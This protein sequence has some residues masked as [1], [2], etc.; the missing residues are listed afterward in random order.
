MPN[1]TALADRGNA[2]EVRVVGRYA[3]YDVIA[4]GGMATVHIGRLLGVAGFA[5]SVAVKRL[6]PHLASDPEFVAMFVDE[7]RLAARVRHP[8]VVQTLDVTAVDGELFLVMDYVHGEPLTQLLRLVRKAGEQMPLTICVHVMCGVLEGLHAAHEAKS[9]RG[10]PLGLV[11]RDVSPQNIIVGVDGIARVLDFGVAKAL[12]RIQSSDDGSLKGKIPYMSPE[13]IRG[14]RVDRTSDVYTSAVVLFEL[15]TGRR[16][17]TGVNEG[18]VLMKVLNGDVPPLA[19]TRQVPAALEA[20]IRRGLRQDPTERFATAHEMALALEKTVSLVTTRE[21]GEWVQRVAAKPLADRAALIEH[22]ERTSSLAGSY[23]APTLEEEL[24]SSRRPDFPARSSRSPLAITDVRPRSFY[25]APRSLWVVLGGS[26]IVGAVV[27]VV[28]L[29]PRGTESAT[30]APTATPAVAA[31]TVEPAPP[32]A[33]PEPAASGSAAPMAAPSATAAASASTT[34]PKQVVKSGKP[35]AAPA[36]PT[37]D[38]PDDFF[39]RN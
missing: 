19:D 36:H 35:G 21:V 16:V 20:V 15:L 34:R 39:G 23:V 14:G 8:N 24:S 9:E 6:H 3:L 2:P 11:H 37:S 18:E 29:V 32:T 13:Q 17:F 5:R 25:S 28:A 27:G 1:D 31:P 26:A 33:A 38:R 10:E 30:V 12:G 4:S 22:V 7:A